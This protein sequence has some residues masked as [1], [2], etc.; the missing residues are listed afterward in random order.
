MA[1]AQPWLTERKKRNWKS[2][3]NK[4]KNLKKNAKSKNK[5]TLLLPFQKIAFAYWI[6]EKESHIQK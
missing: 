3:K 6:F 4:H 2:S 1:S 5:K